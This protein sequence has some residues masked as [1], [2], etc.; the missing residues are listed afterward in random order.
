MPLTITWPV[1]EFLRLIAVLSLVAVIIPSSTA[2]DQLAANHHMG[3]HPLRVHPIAAGGRVES[4]HLAG[5]P[6]HV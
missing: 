2:G 4:H 6:A 1:A 3:A 5:I